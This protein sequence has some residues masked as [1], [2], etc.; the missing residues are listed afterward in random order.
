MV[1][2]TFSKQSSAD[3]TKL[4]LQKKAFL[5][6]KADISKKEEFFVQMFLSQVFGKWK[7][8]ISV[9]ITVC[10]A[11]ELFAQKQKQAF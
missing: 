3:D 2:P 10:I 1:C 8:R 6:I 9:W 5:S 11:C 4:A 7:R